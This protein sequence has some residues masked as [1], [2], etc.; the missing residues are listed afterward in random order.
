MRKNIWQGRGFAVHKRLFP[1]VFYSEQLNNWT[2]VIRI[3]IKWQKT[4]HEI[5]IINVHAPTASKKHEQE[6][7]RFYESLSATFDKYRSDTFVF[8]GG[9]INASVPIL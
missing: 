4:K 3:L 1:S 7:E 2:A 9:A 5:T 8:I 6:T